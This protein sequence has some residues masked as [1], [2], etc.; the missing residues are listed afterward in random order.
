MSST[1]QVS[2]PVVAERMRVWLSSARGPSGAWGYR[3]GDVECLEPTLLAVAAGAP[4]PRDWIERAEPDWA[5]LLAPAVLWPREPDLCKRSTD[6]ILAATSKKN[7]SANRYFDAVTPAWG[8]V[9]GTA[10]WVEPTSYAILSLRRTGRAPERRQNGV[11]MLL[12]RQG[13]DGG[14]NYGNPRMLESALPSDPAPTA[15]ALLALADEGAP[16]GAVDRAFA[17]LEVL[18]QRPSSLALAL[19]ILAARRHRH[20]YTGWLDLL[21]ARL[22]GDHCRDRVDWTALVSLALDPNPV[23]GDDVF[24]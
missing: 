20:P 8:W 7:E 18:H 10:A 24:G 13:D 14:W 19:A 23:G 9:P 3:P 21:T 16:A 4:A 22:T 17:Y 15:W 6:W 2:P 1:P 11:K 12:G 5:C